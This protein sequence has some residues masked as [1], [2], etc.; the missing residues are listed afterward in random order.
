VRFA[1]LGRAG[2]AAARRLV[3]EG[4]RAARA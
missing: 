1:P 3:A 2:A 4:R